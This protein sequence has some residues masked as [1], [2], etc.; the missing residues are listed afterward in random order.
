MWATAPRQSTTLTWSSNRCRT[1]LGRCWAQACKDPLQSLELVHSV[2][3]LRPTC[4]EAL[5]LQR[6]LLSELNRRYPSD[7]APQDSRPV[8]DTT[9]EVSPLPEE[10]KRVVVM[11][12]RSPTSQWLPM[13]LG[14]LVGVAV[15]ALGYGLIAL[16]LWGSIARPNETELLSAHSEATVADIVPTMPTG[17]ARPANRAEQATAFLLVPDRLL[18]SLGR[19]SGSIV[20]SDGLVLTNYHVMA[21]RDGSLA[22]HD[23]LA[24]VG[25]T[26][27]VRQPPTHWYIAALVAAD[28]VTD[29]AVLRIVSTADGRPT[30]GQPFPQMALG[31]STTLALGQ[32]LT[33]LGYPALGG[34]TLTL[35]RGSMAGFAQ[36]ANGSRLG[37]TDSELLP[38]SSGGAVLDEAGRLV[39]VVAS[40][41]VDYRTQGRLSYFI[42]LEEAQPLIAEAQRAPRPHPDLD[43][44]IAL[45]DGTT[46]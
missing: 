12:D 15:V 46:P 20:S 19:G 41:D 45:F 27:D 16:S 34:N 26:T 36:G 6:R 38:G 14:M 43:W 8:T 22:N 9:S 11:P 28:P 31:D 13:L 42:L 17:E 21:R 30:R 1:I 3:Q 25:L 39:G 29:L 32:P 2:L 5:Y 35:T 10:P 37:K 44:M 4:L 24:F 33:A 7:R 18:V 40:A 23:G